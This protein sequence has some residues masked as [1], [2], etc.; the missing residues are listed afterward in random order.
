M[1]IFYS[2]P[3][4]LDQVETALK[5]L[6]QLSGRGSAGEQAAQEFHRRQQTILLADRKTQT[7]SQPVRVFL[8]MGN[9][10]LMTLNG[11]TLQHELIERCGG[12]N[13]FADLKMQAPAVNPEAVLLANPEVILASG[14]GDAM[15]LWRDFPR[16]QAVERKHI[17]TLEADWLFRPGPRILDALQ[18]VCTFLRHARQ[19]RVR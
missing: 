19:D 11:Q 5:T 6:G 7:A 15:A 3:Q 16:L 14:V 13:I 9:A 1:A 10:P 2:N 17:Y 18:Q 12:R 4:R 8:Q